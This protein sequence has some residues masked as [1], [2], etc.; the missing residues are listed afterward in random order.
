MRRLLLLWLLGRLQQQE[1]SACTYEDAENPVGRLL[2]DFGQTLTQ[3]YRAAMRF[4]HWGESEQLNG[5]ESHP[6]KE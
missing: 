5:D 4:V 1:S 6:L 2:D 3:R